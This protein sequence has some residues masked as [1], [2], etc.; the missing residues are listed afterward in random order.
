LKYNNITNATAGE[1]SVLN[2]GNLSLEKNEFDCRIVTVGYILTQTNTTVLNNKTVIVPE[3]AD[4]DVNAT[5]VDDNGNV[6]V[7]RDVFYFNDTIHNIT[8]PSAYVGDVNYGTFHNVEHGISIINVTKGVLLK[9]NVKTGTIIAKGYSNIT[10]EIIKPNEGKE[11]TVNAYIHPN[12]IQGNISFYVNGV[13]YGNYN[14]T[15]GFATLMLY[16]LTAGVYTLTATNAGNLLYYGSSN[17]TFFEIALS[18]P[19]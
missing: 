6:I 12:T 9:N 16:N 7:V 2:E 19:I 15:N 10:F 1:Y 13:P 5:I 11:V 8:R 17:S 4:V 18:K 14:I 3:G